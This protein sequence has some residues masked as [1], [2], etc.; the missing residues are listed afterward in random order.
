MQYQAKAY[1]KD[2][3]LNR[4]KH[5]LDDCPRRGIAATAFLDRIKRGA[6][7]QWRGLLEMRAPGGRAPG[8]AINGVNQAGDHIVRHHGL[9]LPQRISCATG[10]SGWTSISCL[11]RFF[12][13]AG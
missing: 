12:D 7:T 1:Q 10:R 13:G 3:E 5:T 9:T 6:H 2:D 4:G 11:L 8:A